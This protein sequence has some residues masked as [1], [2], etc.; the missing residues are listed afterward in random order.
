MNDHDDDSCLTFVKRFQVHLSVLRIKSSVKSTIN[1]SFRKITVEEML[2]QLQNLDPKKGS[3]QEA[4]P[5][6]ILKSNTDLFCFPLTDLFNKLVE[7]SSFPYDMKILM[8]L[9]SSRR[10]II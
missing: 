4:I 7:E 1:F 9:H 10:M 2:E 3:P 5:A 6:T 8:F